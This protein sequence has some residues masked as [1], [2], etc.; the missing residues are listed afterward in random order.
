MRR[1]LSL[2]VMLAFVAAVAAPGSM[3]DGPG[4]RLEAGQHTSVQT[5]VA[6]VLAECCDVESGMMHHAMAGCAMD[7]STAEPML[8]VS[9]AEDDAGLRIGASPVVIAAF[10]SALFRPPIAV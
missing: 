9:L 3:L 1:V 6:A 7:C 5:T 8:A 10:A 4:Q 2:L